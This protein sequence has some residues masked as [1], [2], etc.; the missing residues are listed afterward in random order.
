MAPAIKY[1]REQE[2]QT[3]IVSQPIDED[4]VKQLVG[5]FIEALALKDD[6]Q[7]GIDPIDKAIGSVLEI[8]D[9]RGKIN[10]AQ[11][12]AI[13]ADDVLLQEEKD[14]PFQI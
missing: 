12:V 2:A 5:A 3:A 11:M 9:I 13:Y 14:D 8:D 1:S 7:A 4:E 10:Q 6:S